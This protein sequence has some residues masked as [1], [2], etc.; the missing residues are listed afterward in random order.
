M[1]NAYTA[2]ATQV[3]PRYVYVPNRRVYLLPYQY[4]NF[5][6]PYHRWMYYYYPEYYG[7]YYNTYWPYRYPRRYQRKYNSHH[8]HRRYP[9]RY[10]HR[11][12]FETA[13]HNASL[14]SMVSQLASM[15]SPLIS[16]IT[17]MASPLISKI[18]PLAS[19]V[20]SIASQVSPLASQIKSMATP[21]ASQITSMITPVGSSTYIPTS[22]SN[23]TTATSYVPVI[24]S[25]YTPGIPNSN[26]SII[27]E[28]FCNVGLNEPD[29]IFGKVKP[30]DT[31]AI[32]FAKSKDYDGSTLFNQYE[33]LNN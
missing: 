20:S 21:L 22:T 24:K 15:A 28:H 13:K 4:L 8:N 18:S 26:N 6:N 3:D 14:G 33:L 16:K 32:K 2:P 5:S 23:A 19:Q 1:E 12:H 17:P 10:G 7:N 31:D 30:Y 9:N 25:A 29:P 27:A 11:E